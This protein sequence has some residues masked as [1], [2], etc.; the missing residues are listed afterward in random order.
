MTTYIQ[1]PASGTGS[2]YWID[3][4]VNFAALPAVGPVD[5][6]VSLTLDN[7]L[8]WRWDA[9][10]VAWVPAGNIATGFAGGFAVVSTAAGIAESLVTTTELGYVSGV[11]SA[12][13]TQ[14]NAKLALAGGTMTGTLVLAGA[15]VGANDAVNLAYLQATVEGFSPKLPVLVSTTA[16]VTLSGEQTLDG[17]LTSASR[18]LVRFQT[19]PAENGIYVSAAGAWARSADMNSWAEVPTAFC[20]V[21]LGT[22]YANTGWLCT[23]APGGTLGTTAIIW[24]QWYGVGTYT[25][26]GTYVALTGTQFSLSAAAATSIDDVQA[27]TAANTALRLVKRDASGDFNGGLVTAETKLKVG[28]A[29]APAASAVAEFASTTGAILFPRMTQTQRD[30]LTGVNGMIVYNTD[31][32]RFDGYV[33]GAWTP[34]HGWGY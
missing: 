16:N 3:A 10:A 28:S 2:S 4:V 18:V 32:D 14:L 1:I 13:Q 12:I 24:G 33:A 34:L 26:D 15:P 5:G 31:T 9:G 19:A 27:A 8:I 21:E 30:A 20:V 22:L 7:S 25:A 23:S 17:V 11:T 29:A 6:A